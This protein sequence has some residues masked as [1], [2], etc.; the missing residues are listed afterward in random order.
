MTFSTSLGGRHGLEEFLRSSDRFARLR[1]GLRMMNGEAVVPVQAA[2][3]GGP[4]G[5]AARLEIVRKAYGRRGRLVVAL[6]AVTISFERATFTAVMGPSGSG[7]STLLNVAAG[8]DRPTSGSVV[9]DG[10]EIGAMG[11]TALTKMRRE[12][13]G[14]VFQAF[15]LLPALTVEQNITLPLRLAGRKPDRARVASVIERIG[16]SGR[17][18]FRPA[19][20]S[21]GQQQRVAIGRAL[22][23][24]PAVIFADEPTGALDTMT[25]RDVLTLLREAVHELGQTVVMVTHDPMAASYGDRVVF[26]ADGRFV[27]E[28]RDPTADAVAQRMT[29]LGAWNDQPSSRGAIGND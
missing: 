3:A 2:P 16:L 11:E 20:L 17:R 25:A 18:A 12:R 23:G 21:G 26:L 15:N 9:L 4:S 10:V 27:G 19:E 1:E 8:L 14:F 28:L 5:D 29:H 7:K 22:L 24:G 13:V 6:E